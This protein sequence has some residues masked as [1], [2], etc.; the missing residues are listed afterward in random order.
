MVDLFEEMGK[1]KPKYDLKY[2]N[3]MTGFARK[4]AIHLGEAQ[5][6]A[7]DLGKF[8]NTQ[9]E[10]YI[11]A[12]FIGLYTKNPIPLGDNEG[13]GFIEIRS[14]RPDDLV[15]YMLMCLFTKAEFDWNELEDMDDKGVEREMRHLSKL[16]EAYANGGLEYIS[17]LVKENPSFFDDDYCFVKLLKQVEI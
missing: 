16:L 5:E 12:F 9:Y 8:F 11:Y 17:S 14:W 7:Y 10:F 13:K 6:K 4:G 3:L 1:K 15:R 2:E